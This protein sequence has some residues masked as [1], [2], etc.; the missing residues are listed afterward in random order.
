MNLWRGAFGC[1]PRAE[2]CVPTSPSPALG[3]PQGGLGGNSWMALGL[4]GAER[5]K[6]E[7]GVHRDLG[8]P[9]K[10]NKGSGMSPRHRED[11]RACQT[12]P[13]AP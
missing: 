8:H 6:G 9:K 7:S 4:E 2:A 11:D 12:P 5:Q 1:I 10:D 13:S 3:V